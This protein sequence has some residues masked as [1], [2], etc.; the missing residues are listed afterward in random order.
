[1][2][3]RR[4]ILTFVFFSEYNFLVMCD[5]WGRIL[6]HLFELAT[7]TNLCDKYKKSFPSTHC[8]ITKQHKN[9]SSLILLRNHQTSNCSDSYNSESHV[10]LD[11]LRP[12][13]TPTW[14]FLLH[15]SWIHFS[16]EHKRSTNSFKQL[17]LCFRRAKLMSLNSSR[18]LV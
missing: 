15:W 2:K 14:D 11:S 1:M 9:Y 7:L 16:A 12:N 13:T 5:I 10:A 6:W 4:I 3:Y 8:S 17:L 18:Q